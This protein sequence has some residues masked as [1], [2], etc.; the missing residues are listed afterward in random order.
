MSD[1]KKTHAADHHAVD[2]QRGPIGV[3]A[4]ATEGIR[5]VDMP[6][7]HKRTGLEHHTPGTLPGA[8]PLRERTWVHESGYGGKNGEARTS[9][10]TREADEHPVPRTPLAEPPLPDKS[11]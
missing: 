3:G 11:A 6:G 9:S 1:D 7:P 10:E 8:E 4:E 5:D 2:R